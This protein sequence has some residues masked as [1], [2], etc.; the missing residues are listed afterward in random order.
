MDIKYQYKSE[1][2]NNKSVDVYFILFLLY[3]WS[4]DQPSCLKS[5]FYWEK[6]TN[7]CNR[8]ELRGADPDPILKKTGFRS[9]YQEKPDP[10]VGANVIFI[11]IITFFITLI[12]KYWR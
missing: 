12:N 3:P 7:L 2:V 9:D 8:P 4:K 6:I 10:A 1:M 11:Y 5:M